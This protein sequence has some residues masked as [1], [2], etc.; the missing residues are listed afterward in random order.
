MAVTLDASTP[1]AVYQD[2]VGATS[3]VTASFT[4]PSGSIVVAKVV[5]SDAGETSSTPTGLTFTSRA[6]IGTSGAT[7]RVAL[8][9][10]TGGGSAVTVTAGFGGT[11]NQAR[12]LIVE[13]WS[14]AQLVGTPAVH[15]LL[16]WSGAPLDTITTVAANS[17]VSWVSG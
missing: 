14:G 4:P 13:V 2:T 5:A 7:T 15:T 17:V 11:G 10:A 8:Y 1:A 16:S 9:T 6:N 12:A 3:L